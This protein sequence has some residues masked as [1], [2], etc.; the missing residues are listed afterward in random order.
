MKAI[1]ILAQADG[2]RLDVLS[3]N[4]LKKYYIDVLFLQSIAKHESERLFEQ[5]R[6]SK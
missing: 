6:S 5:W 3:K 2:K 4:D 1:E